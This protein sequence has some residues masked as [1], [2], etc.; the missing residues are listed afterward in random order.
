MSR[1]S[2]CDALLSNIKSTMQSSNLYAR[3]SM[4]FEKCLN[5]T[6]SHY[7][8]RNELTRLKDARKTRARGIALVFFDV[9]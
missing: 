4:G 2:H 8:K 9:L 1:E 5:R 6:E 3:F 7:V